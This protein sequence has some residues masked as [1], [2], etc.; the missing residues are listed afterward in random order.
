MDILLYILYGV[1]GL[2]GLLGFMLYGVRRWGESVL[3]RLRDRTALRGEDWVRGDGFAN[4]RG[5]ASDGIPIRGNAVVLLTSRAF[6]IVILWPRKEIEIPLERLVRLEVS[7]SFMGRFEP[8]GFLILHHRTDAG[9]DAIGLTLRRLP[10]WVADIVKTARPY[11][12]QVQGQKMGTV[13][14]GPEPAQ[15]PG[16]AAPPPPAAPDAP[17][18]PPAASEASPPTKGP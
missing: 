5:R 1:L 13:G 6:R 15:D 2:T 11:L 8:D 10:L 3:G 18:P 9:G 17:I 7:R 4:F 16:G 14:A 12:Q